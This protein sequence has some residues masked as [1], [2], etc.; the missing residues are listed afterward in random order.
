MFRRDHPEYKR[1]G[2]GKRLTDYLP[3]GMF[4]GPGI[5]RLKSRGL[6]RVFEFRP[7][8]A[9]VASPHVQ[10]SL[11]DRIHGAL[12]RLPAGM[13]VFVEIQ[14]CPAPLL[15]PELTTPNDCARLIEHIRHTNI[16]RRGQAW[17]TRYF[18]TLTYHASRKR[19]SL[20]ERVLATFG[21]LFQGG[22]ELDPTLSETELHMRAEYERF[23]RI[24]ASFLTDVRRAFAYA[25]WLDDDQTMTYLH[26]CV[27]GL[28]HPVH[29]PSPPVYIDVAIADEPVELGLEGRLGAQHLG[30]VSIK[31]YPNKTHPNLLASL[32]RFPY[33]VRLV[34]RYKVFDVEQSVIM[35]KGYENVFRSQRQKLN[36][37]ISKNSDN[38]IDKVAV[39]SANRIERVGDLVR[40]GYHVFGDH[41]ATLV[42]LGPNR[43]TLRERLDEV[44]ATLRQLGF[45]CT[46]ETANL[47]SAWLSS[48]PGQVWSN[49][50]R[51]AVSSRN[52]GHM[53]PTRGV[54]MGN[55]RNEH[56]DL[57]ALMTCWASGR[58]PFFLNTV[59]GKTGH[60]T[61][62]GPNGT[63]KSVLL[64]TMVLNFARYPGAQVYIFDKKRSAK[65]PTLACGGVHLELG[66]GNAGLGFQP[67]RRI[68]EPAEFEFAAS[69]IEQLVILASGSSDD[70]TRQAIRQALAS[71]ALVPKQ[72]RTLSGFKIYVQDTRIRRIL[73][74]Y[75]DPAAFGAMWD[76]GHESLELG[77]I[78][79]FEMNDLLESAKS[80]PEQDGSQGTHAGEALVSLTLTY[81]FHRLGERF[82]QGRP[83]LLL[84]DEAWSFLDTPVFERRIR[85]WLKELRKL[86]V[87]VI[88]ASQNIAEVLD[89]S[90]SATI[91]QEVKT[92]IYLPNAEA[93]AP[94]IQELYQSMNLSLSQIQRI[95]SA[96]PMRDYYL[97]QP[98][99]ARLFELGLSPLELALVGVAGA[100]AR[101]VIPVVLE[102]MKRSG[103]TFLSCYLEYTGFG[104]YAAWLEGGHR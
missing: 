63:G 38:I 67:L 100:K 52:F 1:P 24:T 34:H 88:F 53:I 20:L 13:A 33:P 12:S 57:P 68:D 25:D 79:C 87:Y 81:L 75:T 7:Q 85:Q 14:R 35:L 6:V 43:E 60:A 40:E 55:P 21:G 93:M 64:N 9:S 94:R 48:L 91:V 46:E 99:E 65:V 96:T 98:G 45:A 26:S 15:E 2:R 49:A 101:E 77:D 32:E 11:H 18:V 72:D 69:W 42:V 71:L 27:S 5:I 44:S 41:T 74:P 47:K 31:G 19:R 22:E 102:R 80:A 73:A 97:V 30:V 58:Q 84:L 86:N 29:A 104:S 17:T 59:V 56:L 16:S 103:R 10:S 37:A 62:L 28:Y 54:W 76:R 39:R 92:K 78:V 23:E 90:I 89:S 3:Y 66:V 70:T 36:P 61:V 51:S 4:E 82:E 8:D 50:R 83:T 95:A